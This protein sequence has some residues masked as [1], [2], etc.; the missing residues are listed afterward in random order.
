MSETATKSEEYGRSMFMDAE[1][2]A[3]HLSCSKSE[4]YKL[5]KRGLIPSRTIGGMVRIPRAEFEQ[6]AS[7]ALKP[8]VR[9]IR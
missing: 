4:V 7:G 6:W 5:A 2:A 1:E 9:I 3:H 8:S